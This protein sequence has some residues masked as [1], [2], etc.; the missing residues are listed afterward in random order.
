MV[1]NPCMHYKKYIGKETLSCQRTLL[2]I[3][4]AMHACRQLSKDLKLEGGGSG[5]KGIKTKKPKAK[6]SSKKDEKDKKKPKGKS[7]TSQK[8][9]PSK[10]PKTSRK[11]RSKG[12]EHAEEAGSPEATAHSSKRSRKGD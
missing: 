2:I 4:M 9:N 11:T 12:S 10:K 8:G 7:K 5:S 1:Q 3:P 6:P